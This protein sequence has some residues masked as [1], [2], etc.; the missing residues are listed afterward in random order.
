MMYEF[1]VSEM[2]EEFGVHRNT[3]RNWINAGTLSAQEGPGRKYL[4]KFEDYQV[5]C[6]KFGREP[7]IRPDSNI[8]L[9]TVRSLEAEKG[10]MPV[11]ELGKKVKTLYDDTQWADECL[12]CGTCASACPLSGVDGLD[13]RKVVRMAFLGLEDDLITSDWAWKCTMCAKC[14]DVCPANIQIVQLM[15]RIRSRRERDKVPGPIHKGV[16]TCLERGNNI[17]IPKEDFLN[18]VEELGEELSEESCPG[19]VT[20]VDIHGARIM[21]TVNSREPFAEPDD[22]KWWWKIFHAAGESWT[23]T[24][25]NWEGVNWGLFSGDDESMRTVV[26]R[27]V[28]NMR[29][30]N[31]EMLL[32]PECGH[33]YYATRLGLNRWYPEA[34]K[35]FKICTIFDLLLEYINTG[36]IKVDNT[37]HTKRTVY[38]DPCNYGRKSMKAFGQAYYEE[39]RAITR[40]CCP[41]L[42]EMEPNRGANYCCGAGGGAWA[43]PFADERVYY[44]RMKARQVSESEAKLVIA[45][46]HN[47]RDQLKKSLNQEYS[48]GVEVKY[49]WELVADS[50]ILPVTGKNGVAE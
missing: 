41:D 9:K 31:C 19:F 49:M 14:E 34:L 47:C 48:L 38:H 1:K 6:E 42:V 23:L 10:V 39:G 20:P 37:L 35:E 25:E 50:L 13:P 28:D 36:R 27:I 8:D 21:V 17:G 29:R 5:L 2:A 30:L 45:S 11:L 24:S 4:M 43:M 26:G 40:A 12:T 16:V 18:L 32:L 44:G 22:L 7:L 15:R 33:A 3:I 46:C